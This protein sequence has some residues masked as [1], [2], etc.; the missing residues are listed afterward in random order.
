MARVAKARSDLRGAIEIYRDLL[1]YGADKKWMA[2]YEPR[3]VLEIARLLDKM[4]DKATARQEYQRFLD[5]WK[6]ADPDLPELAEA[7]HA[8]AR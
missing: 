8:L 6:H 2:P 3:Y 7:R 4:G 1:T 5:S